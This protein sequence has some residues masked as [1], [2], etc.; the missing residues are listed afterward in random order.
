[1]YNSCIFVDADIRISEK[2]PEY[3]EFSPGILAFSSCSMIKFMTKKNDRPNIRNKKYWLNQEIITKVANYW[4]IN[5]EKAKF[6]Q[7]YFFTVTKNEK[8]DD[9]LKT[10]EILAGYFE[11]KSIYAGEGN[12][13][14]LAAAKAEFP[15]NYD[16]EKRIKFFKDRVTLAKIRKEQE[17][18]E[19]ELQFLKERRSIAYYPNIF[20]KINKRLKKKLVFWIRLLILKITNSG[21]QEIYRCF[22]GQIKNN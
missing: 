6:V 9:F 1:M 4:Q 22:D 16:Y 17:V 19:Q 2:L 8:F 21:Y 5:L 14:G 10:W 18:N 13:I 20:V 11:L 12:I 3:L 7:E 15:L